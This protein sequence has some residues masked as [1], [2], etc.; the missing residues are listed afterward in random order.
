MT[1]SEPIS[2]SLFDRPQSAGKVRLSRPV[3]VKFVY[4]RNEIL[5]KGRINGGEELIFSFSTTGASDTIID[6]R[7]A[8][9]HFLAKQGRQKHDGLVW[10]R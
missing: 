9:E 6:R 5:V 10:K 3:K 7:V 2:D 8:A 1:L 4:D